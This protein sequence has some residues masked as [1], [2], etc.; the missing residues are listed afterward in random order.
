MCVAEIERMGTKWMSSVKEWGEN[1]GL[2][3]S[4]SK[5][6]TILMK[7]SMAAGRRPIVRMNGKLMR[8]AES[9]KYLGI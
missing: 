2:N 7:G 9:V 3:V 8:Y 4:E 6:V 1:V 5:T